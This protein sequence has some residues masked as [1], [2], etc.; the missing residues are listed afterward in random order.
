MLNGVV[1]RFGGSHAPPS[2]TVVPSFPFILPLLTPGRLGLG[3]RHGAAT[4]A[5]AEL[6]LKG[7]NPPLQ[8][9]DDGL[10]LDDDG[11]LLDDDGLLL[12]NEGKELFV[13]GCRQ[14]EI[15]FHSVLLSRTRVLLFCDNSS[16][17]F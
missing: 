8:L 12:C 15:L 5:R 9:L 10:L 3:A 2:E 1:Y 11:L 7:R 13:I 17:Y 4:P 16:L 6:R 14:I